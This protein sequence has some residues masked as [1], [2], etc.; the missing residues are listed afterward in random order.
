MSD[1]LIR[2]RADGKQAEGEAA[3]VNRSLQ[4]IERTGAR[5][6]K[7]FAGA[8]AVRQIADMVRATVE[9]GGKI[10][11]AA[12]KTGVAAESLQAFNYAAEQSGANLQDI[13]QALKFLSKAMVE[14]SANPKGDIASTFE[15]LGVATKDLATSKPEQLFRYLAAAFQLL[16]D[17]AQSTADALKLMGRGAD[18]L[19]PAF[20]DGFGAAVEQAKTLGIVV[21]DDII[22][23]LDDMGDRMAR[24]R[25]IWSGWMANAVGKDKSFSTGIDFLER[26]SKDFT[27]RMANSSMVSRVALSIPM[28][29]ASA[30]SALGEMSASSKGG[31]A[32]VITQGMYNEVIGALKDIRRGINDL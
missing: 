20:R 2:F 26:F 18:N 32:G 16:P 14:A 30:S 8:F 4:N 24:I 12:S 28:A 29:V 6:G 10:N 3:A 31:T 13:T 11:D 9:W 17:N 27:G 19:L 22:K 21:Q 5:M 1:F 23:R 7:A 25:A 15:R